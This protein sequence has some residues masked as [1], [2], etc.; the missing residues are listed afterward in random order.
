MSTVACGAAPTPTAAELAAAADSDLG[1][2]EAFDENCFGVGDLNASL[3]E[4]KQQGWVEFTP[5]ADSVLE[6]HR[7]MLLDGPVFD[8]PEVVFLRKNSNRAQ[9]VMWETRTLSRSDYIFHCE[10][11]EETASTLDLAALEEWTN[12]P[13]EVRQIDDSPEYHDLVG[14]RFA[15]GGGGRATAYFTTGQ[16]QRE[17]LAG[18]IVHNFRSSFAEERSE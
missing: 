14:G 9:V 17:T 16:G 2:F 3:S 13:I 1:A 10:V 4:A 11:V 6:K 8:R 18:L 15:N 12:V 7:D 5:P